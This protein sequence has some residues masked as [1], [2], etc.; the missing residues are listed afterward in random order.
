MIRLFCLC[1]LSLVL[2]ACQTTEETHIR[3]GDEIRLIEAIPAARPDWLNA[4]PQPD[5]R[6]YYFVGISE[7]ASMEAHAKDLAVADALKKAAAYSGVSIS[8]KSER[9][10]ESR[11]KTSE[12]ADPSI[13]E[14]EK[15]LQSARAY[16]S[17]FH[18]D[19]FYVE[20][21]GRMQKKQIMDSSFRASV[22][23]SIP[24]DE[25]ESAIN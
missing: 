23:L 20:H 21:F 7:N 12:T 6:Y 1:L 16:F 10:T 19:Q 5:G 24:T 17:R 4:T 14:M 22:L 2:S 11:F 3:G 8:Y 13:S 9:I 15:L 25:V 18:S